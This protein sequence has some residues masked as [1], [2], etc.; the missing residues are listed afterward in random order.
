ML[1]IGEVARRSGVTASALRYYERTGLIPAGER[2]GGK[3]VYGDELLDRLA[4]IR[5]AKTAGFRLTEIRTLLR[6]FDRRT[7]PGARRKASPSGSHGSGARSCPTR[8]AASGCPLASRGSSKR[9]RAS[10]RSSTGSSRSSANAA[11]A[12]CSSSAPARSPAG[13]GSKCAE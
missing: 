10:P 2:S 11:T 4:L 6:G 13:F 9:L 7:P 1:S 3:R 5:V 12:S 8:V